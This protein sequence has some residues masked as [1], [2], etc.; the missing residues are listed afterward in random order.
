MLAT[1]GKHLFSAE[2][3]LIFDEF[4]YS[5]QSRIKSGA[6]KESY[7]KKLGELIQLGSSNLKMTSWPHW[8]VFHFQFL[9]FLKNFKSLEFFPLKLIN[10]FLTIHCKVDFSLGELVNKRATFVPCSHG[11]ER[12]IFELF[13]TLFTPLGLNKFIDVR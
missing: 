10:H 2:E 7:F 4:S 12:S 3:F 9:A 8:N 6:I 11:T 13:L 5:R 1:N